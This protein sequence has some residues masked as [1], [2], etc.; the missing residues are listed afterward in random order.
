MIESK[1]GKLCSQC[2]NKKLCGGC[3][4]TDRRPFYNRYCEIA[5]CSKNKNIDFCGDCIEF[6]CKML[7]DVS[8]D[9][10]YGDNPKGLRIEQCNQWKEAIVRVDSL[11]EMAKV[12]SSESNGKKCAPAPLGN[13]EIEK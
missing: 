10:E 6:P 12:R 5:N 9:L 3:V 4:E 8:N 1:C 7:V 2:E 11:I 13:I